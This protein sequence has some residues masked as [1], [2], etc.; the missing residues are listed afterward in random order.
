[1]LTTRTFIALG[2]AFAL[3]ITAA[4]AQQ[5]PT[6]TTTDRDTTEAIST[7]TA[8]GTT[9]VTGTTAPAITTATNA[10]TAPAI[11]T[12]TSATTAPAVKVAT[13]GTTATATVTTPTATVTASRQTTPPPSGIAGSFESLSPGNRTIADSLYESQ[14]GPHR[15]S[16]DQI[17]TAKLSGDGWG[18]IF[19]EMRRDGLIHAKSLGQVIRSDAG[20]HVVRRDRD[21]FDHHEH[22][23]LAH[24]DHDDH[25]FV[26]HFHH[27]ITVTSASGA[28]QVVSH[29]GWRHD[30]WNNGAGSHPMAHSTGT[31]TASAHG[32]PVSTQFSEAA[33]ISGNSAT[34]HHGSAAPHHGR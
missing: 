20:R 33:M 25:H 5:A 21:D 6:G 29:G 10:T 17:A 2:A 31:A 1:M 3:G 18:Q 16:R 8:T 9:T 15:W 4:A 27:E 28:S 30:G 32:A 7:T 11:T 22:H 34:M 12:T 14:R 24:H 23:N 26:A 19:H 13:T